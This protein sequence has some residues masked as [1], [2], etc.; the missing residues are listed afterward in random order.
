MATGTYPGAATRGFADLFRLATTAYNSVRWLAFSFDLGFFRAF[1]RLA[2]PSPQG[3]A[4]ISLDIH[5]DEN[6]TVPQVRSERG[7]SIGFVSPGLRPRYDSARDD[8]QPRRARRAAA[9]L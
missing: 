5:G 9:S 3:N 7:R 8:K 1:D 4:L 6:A 2:W